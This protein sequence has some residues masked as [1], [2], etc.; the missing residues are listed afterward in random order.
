MKPMKLYNLTSAWGC[1]QATGDEGEIPGTNPD[2]LFVKNDND[3]TVGCKGTWQS[4][5]NALA[6]TN[7]ADGVENFVAA[8]KPAASSN[9]DPIPIEGVL[10]KQITV[11]V[12]LL[13]NL[14]RRFVLTINATFV[15]TRPVRFYDITHVDLR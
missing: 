2:A 9:L 14:E 4:I 1:Y 5:I 6:Y 3:I 15:S 11:F 7:Y 13:G 12:G 10:E 8:N